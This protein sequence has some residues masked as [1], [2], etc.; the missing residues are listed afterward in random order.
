MTATSR[1]QA[2][3]EVQI[4]NGIF[5][6][7]KWTFPPGAETGHHVHEYEFVVVPILSGDLTIESHTEE[8]FVAAIE[9]GVSY[10]RAKG[11]AHNVVNNTNATISFVEVELLQE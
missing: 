1:S 5:R 8:T 2:T 11:V 6:S 4:D 10:T 9:V 7:T 3:A